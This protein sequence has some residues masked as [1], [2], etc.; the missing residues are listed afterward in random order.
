MVTEIFRGAYATVFDSLTF[1][2]IR[3][4]LT[5]QLL[6]TEPTIQTTDW[7][8]WLSPVSAQDREVA[9]RAIRPIHRLT[10]S[11]KVVAEILRTTNPTRSLFVRITIVCKVL[12]EILRTTFTAF[13]PT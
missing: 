5:K 6:I 4:M 8:P 7:L 12:A 3:E 2:V 11:V 9:I 13:L 10:V 1:A